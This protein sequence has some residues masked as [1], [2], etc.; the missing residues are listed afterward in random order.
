M[1]ILCKKCK[2]SQVVKNG[3]QD[4]IQRYKCKDC[5][6]VFRNSKPKYSEDFKMDVIMMHVNSVGFRAIARIKK[7]H[8]S[9]VS[10]W[11]KKT[12]MIVKEKFIAETVKITDKN[13]KILEIDE[14]YTYVKKNQKMAEKISLYGLLVT[15]TTT[16]LLILK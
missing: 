2:S 5:L 1:K 11:I 12:G 4:N 16:E 7:I 8:N 15:E 10:Y 13:I 3:N 9:L 6:A 14:L